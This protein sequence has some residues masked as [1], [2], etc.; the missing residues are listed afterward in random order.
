LEKQLELIEAEEG[1]RQ[2][3]MDEGGISSSDEEYS[4][5]LRQRRLKRKKEKLKSIQNANNFKAGKKFNLTIPTGFAFDSRK[6]P[7]TIR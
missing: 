4:K 5:E 2:K 1:E 3:R 7:V 6:K